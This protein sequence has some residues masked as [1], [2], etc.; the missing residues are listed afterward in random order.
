MRGLRCNNFSFGSTVSC[1]CESWQSKVRCV[2]VCV[3]VCIYMRRDFL[4]FSFPF[5][6]LPLNRK[7]AQYTPCQRREREGWLIYVS[8]LQVC[9]LSMF[10]S[11][12]IFLQLSFSLSFFLSFFASICCRDHQNIQHHKIH[13]VSEPT[14]RLSNWS[15][16]RLHIKFYLLSTQVLTIWYYKFQLAHSVGSYCISAEQVL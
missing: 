5:S 4:P 2:R 6:H 1:A 15:L 14:K 8:T 3:C 12:T 11:E 16:S 13:I 7:H 10:V 9:L